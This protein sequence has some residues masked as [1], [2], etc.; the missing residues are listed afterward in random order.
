MEPDVKLQMQPKKIMHLVTQ[1]NQPY[2][3]RCK[4]CESCGLGIHAMSA[5]YAYVD[6]EVNFT[7]EFAAKYN[8]IR[9]VD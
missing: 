4:C 2:G 8:E 9:C 5:G 6:E 1:R 7:E 3:S